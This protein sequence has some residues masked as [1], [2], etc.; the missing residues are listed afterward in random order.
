[1]LKKYSFFIILFLNSICGYGQ[2]VSTYT[3]IINKVYSNLNEAIGVSQIPPK[4]TITDSHEFVAQ[5]V[6]S[7]NQIQIETDAYEV[8]RTLGKDSLNALAY[9]LGHE[10]AHYYKDHKWLGKVGSGFVSNR[11]KNNL[12]SLAIAIDTTILFETQADEFGCYYAKKAGYSLGKTDSLLIKIYSAYNLPEKLSSRYPSLQERIDIANSVINK[13]NELNEIFNWANLLFALNREQSAQS[14]LILF[15]HIVNSE[16]QP[17]EI[18]NN[19]GV[20]YL[21]MSIDYIDVQMRNYYLPLQ[22][23]VSSYLEERSRG[24]NY[25]SLK[26]I[27]NVNKSLEVLEIANRLDESYV[28]SRINMAVAYLLLKNNR[29]AKYF[30]GEARELMTEINSN[31]LI[32]SK[33]EYIEFLIENIDFKRN[34]LPD[35]KVIAS[36]GNYYAERA[37][38]ELNGIKP[39]GYINP[40]AIQAVSPLI[41]SIFKLFNPSL[42]KNTHIQQLNG[43]SKSR[44]KKIDHDDFSVCEIN[45]KETNAGFNAIFKLVKIKPSN[46]L[47]NELRSILINEYEKN[48]QLLMDNFICITM[49]DG[50]SLF[51][52]KNKF[53]SIIEDIYIIN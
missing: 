36:K 25:D 24:S 29:K 16:I 10:L 37:L 5:F 50:Y 41:D 49:K 21:L 7:R 15:N 23:D 47:Y 42:F 33:I 17:R 40:L 52:K 32:I 26:A 28:F 48:N 3:N 31:P 4:L 6:T 45:L 11:L 30:I 13:S 20:C 18:Y 19:I 35:L 39:V 43:T 22:I 2:S 38:Q 46:K 1:M 12:D 27:E 51:I 53:S 8:C 34:I 14:A 44:Y 9:I